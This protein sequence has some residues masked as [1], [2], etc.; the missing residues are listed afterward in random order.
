MFGTH[1][2]L[3]PS[4]AANGQEPDFTNNAVNLNN[5]FIGTLDYIFLVN[6]AQSLAAVQLP[7]RS[8]VTD[9]P[10]PNAREPSDHTAVWCDVQV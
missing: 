5:A 6:G 2:L 3:F 7:H 9:G 1:P 10:Y 8:A 4:R